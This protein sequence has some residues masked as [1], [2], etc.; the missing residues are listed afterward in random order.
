[1]KRIKAYCRHGQGE[2]ILQIYNWNLVL[3]KKSR[4]PASSHPPLT[5]TPPPQ[6]GSLLYLL[7]PSHRVSIF[8]PATYMDSR[9]RILAS[10]SS[11]VYIP[12]GLGPPLSKIC[13]R[14]ILFFFWGGGIFFRT[15]FS[16]AASAAPQIRLWPM[17]AGIEP[18]TVATGAFAVRR[19][20]Q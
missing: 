18:R 5:R 20:N 16:T 10:P 19:S 6:V 4:L 2:D 12:H 15:V 7:I 1:M 8:N 14:H 17:D 13:S 3:G 11:T 9:L